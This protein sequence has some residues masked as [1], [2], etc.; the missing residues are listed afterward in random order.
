MCK[1]WG[2]SC[3]ICAPASGDT[4]WEVLVPEPRPLMTSL[5]VALQEGRNHRLLPLHVP[6]EIRGCKHPCEERAEEPGRS[7]TKVEEAL[8]GG[9]ED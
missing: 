5:C 2:S 9:Q 1:L 8:A 7:S 4:G 6:A 3:P